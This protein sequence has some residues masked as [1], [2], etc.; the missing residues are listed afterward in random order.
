MA[1][2]SKLNEE[3]IENLCNELREGLPITYACDLF[4]V[5]ARSF[6]NWMEQGKQDLD[7][8]IESIYTQFF[9]KIKKS[10]AEYIHNANAD[11]RSG[12]PGWQGAAWWLERTRSDFMPKQ[13][14]QADEDGKVTVVIGG[15]VKNNVN[16][17]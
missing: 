4:M 17:K 13:Q 5:T 15:K 9:L 1:R 11:I 2:P 14:I 8:D 3:L 7:N 10:Q 16:N 12:R 6:S